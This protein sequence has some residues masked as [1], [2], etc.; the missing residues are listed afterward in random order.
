MHTAKRCLP[1]TLLVPI[2]LVPSFSAAADLEQEARHGASLMMYYSGQVQDTKR[3]GLATSRD[4]VHFGRF[5]GNPV[6]GLGPAGAFDDVAVT[7][8]AAIRVGDKIFLYYA[9]ESSELVGE[10]I[11][12]SI[13]EDGG[14]T[15]EKH[16]ANPVIS[17][18]PAGSADELAVSNPMVL[19]IDGIFYCWYAAVDAEEIE[20]TGLATSQDGVHWTKVPSNP[21]I[22]V[23]PPGSFDEL[24]VSDP[25][26]I[27]LRLA[28]GN[29]FLDYYT[30]VSTDTGQDPEGQRSIG[31]AFSLDGVNW[32]KLPF[33]TVET[34]PNG[35][36]DSFRVGNAEVEFL[37]GKLFM[38]YG[39]REA[40]DI[41]SIGL[42]LSRDG[43]NFTKR[44][45]PV[46]SPRPGTWEGTR[47]AN[48]SVIMQEQ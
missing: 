5:R 43:L 16:A 1:A 3:I 19:R 8:P 48:A 47:I 39:G 31:L 44:E 29:L 27:R 34:G 41:G 20:R 36:F 15:F 26:I 7:D 21:V 4:G 25:G 45:R 23:G 11:G 10:Q 6:L 40:E 2:L 33:P 42:A 18:G 14:F 12:L 37:R 9:A 38:Y 46:L 13:S 32:A 28:T 24:E 30:A 17:V 22:D 35:A